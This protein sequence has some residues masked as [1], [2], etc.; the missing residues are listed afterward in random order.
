MPV[1]PQTGIFNMFSGLGGKTTVIPECGSSF[2]SVYLAGTL[3]S[4]RRLALR[5]HGQLDDSALGLCRD[6]GSHGHWWIGD[7]PAGSLP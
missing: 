5:C 3:A 7:G 4:A 6:C 1:P 2:N